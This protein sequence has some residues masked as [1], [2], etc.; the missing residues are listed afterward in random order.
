[1]GRDFELEFLCFSFVRLTEGFFYFEGDV[2]G[3]KRG[4]VVGFFL[5]SFVKGPR[6]LKVSVYGFL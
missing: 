4:W 3:L 1:M 6:C 5:F 2:S